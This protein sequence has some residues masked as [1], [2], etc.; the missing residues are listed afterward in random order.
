MSYVLCF[1]LRSCR[2]VRLPI[3]T[4][5]C[6]R[7]RPTINTSASELENGVMKEEGGRVWWII[8]S[9]TSCGWPGVCVSLTWRRDGTRMHYGKKVSQW[10]QSYWESGHFVDAIFNSLVS[11]ISLY[12]NSIQ[13]WQC[14]CPASNIC[15]GIVWG[16]RQRVQGNGLAS[17]FRNYQ[18]DWA[19]VGCAAPNYSTRI[20]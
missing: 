19:S 13:E 3:L 20:C 15:L 7:K 4:L 9:F 5:V 1:V 2:P 8:F 18:S 16:T 14:P 11:V 12:G 6:H 10:K 17:K